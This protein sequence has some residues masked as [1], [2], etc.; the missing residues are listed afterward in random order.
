M[1]ELWQRFL[2]SYTERVVGSGFGVCGFVW[3]HFFGHNEAVGFLLTAMILDYITGMLAAY[4]YKREHPRSKKGLDSRVGAIGI[5]KK[6]LILCIVALSHILDAAVSFDGI[7]AAVTW[8]YI[9]NEGLSIIE[10]AAKC[11]TP[12]P[13]KILDVLEQLSGEKER[14]DKPTRKRTAKSDEKEP[15]KG[16]IHEDE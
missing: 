5:L 3:N 9:G 6:V 16:N 8:F 11:G 15:T 13:R 4:F 12:M 1:N 10:N 7:E 2:P 14:V